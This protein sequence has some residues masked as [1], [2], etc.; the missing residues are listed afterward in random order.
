[1][2]GSLNVLGL[3]PLPTCTFLSYSI[4]YETSFR[5][6]A[7]KEGFDGSGASIKADVTIAVWKV[8][9]VEPSGSHT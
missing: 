9:T 6:T 5:W 2:G 1:M 4:A 3:E 7:V 8:G